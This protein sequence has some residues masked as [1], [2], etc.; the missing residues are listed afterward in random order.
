MKMFQDAHRFH[1]K[2]LDDQALSRYIYLAAQGYE[3]ANYNSGFILDSTKSETHFQ[4]AAFFYS[5]SA[6]MG[7]S[8]ARK[9]LGDAYFKI[10]DSS[11]AVAHYLISAKSE[12]PDPEAFFNL[13]YAYETGIGL[14]KDLWSAI[15]MYKVSLVHGKSGKLAVSFAVAKCRFKIFLS[16]LK[17][18]KSINFKKSKKRTM[19]NRKVTDKLLSILAT[20]LITA[21]IYGYF[22]YYQ[23]FM[24]RRFHQNLRREDQ[25]YIN[26]EVINNS[27]PELSNEISRSIHSD[28][29]SST[30]T[31]NNVEVATEFRFRKSFSVEAEILDSFNEE[32]ID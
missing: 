14:K 4:R 29:S 16:D 7:N 15:D 12:N 18:L 5:R 27:S 20:L 31:E 30:V 32:E 1:I 28:S 6:K 25:I 13:G 8:E 23:P 19:S 3:I 21:L 24:Q 11:A 22:N 17:T 9:K 2:G 26:D 10:G